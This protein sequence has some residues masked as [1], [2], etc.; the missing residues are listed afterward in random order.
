MIF[1]S[2]KPSKRVPKKITAGLRTRKKLKGFHDP[3]DIVGT[4]VCIQGK[5]AL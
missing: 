3:N 4:R 1:H 2:R 5:E